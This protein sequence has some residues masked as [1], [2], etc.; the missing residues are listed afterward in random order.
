MKLIDKVLESAKRELRVGWAKSIMEH[1]RTSGMVGI[2]AL[3]KIK[4]ADST[5]A[6][7]RL[8]LKKSKLVKHLKW[9]NFDEVMDEN[10]FEKN[11]VDSMPSLVASDNMQYW[12]YIFGGL[13]IVSLLAY[14]AIKYHRSK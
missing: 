10:H 9:L 7:Y 2:S 5:L 3:S 14:G 13:L 8:G 12:S 11:Y 4:T 6:G 1:L